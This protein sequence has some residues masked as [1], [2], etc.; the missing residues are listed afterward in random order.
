MYKCNQQYKNMI[1]RMEMSNSEETSCLYT[2]KLQRWHFEIAKQ[3]ESIFVFFYLKCWKDAS[4]RKDDS[5]NFRNGPDASFVH[6]HVRYTET[7]AV[8]VAITGLVKYVKVSDS[9]KAACVSK[10]KALWIFA[11]LWCRSLQQW[12]TYMYEKCHAHECITL[13]QS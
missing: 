7:C 8:P 1:S 13:T 2:V 5:S 9:S 11:G 3:G 10:V 4:I 12:N 6:F